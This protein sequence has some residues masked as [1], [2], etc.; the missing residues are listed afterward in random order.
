MTVFSQNEQLLKLEA[1]FEK[2][3]YETR[4]KKLK[5]ID[6]NKLSIPERALVEH[7]YG[8][9][10]YLYNSGNGAV[11][12]FIKAK[13]LYLKARDYDKATE[14]SLTI[15]EQKRLSEYKYEEYKPLLDEAIKYAEKSNK[16]N[17]L[18]TT[19][20][21]V[22]INLQESEPQK[23]IEFHKKGLKIAQRIK[24]KIYEV[25]FNRNIGLTYCEFL[26][27]FDKALYYQNLSLEQSKK[28]NYTEGI[29]YA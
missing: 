7:L 8:K 3:D 13:N 9:T 24:N 16:E 11:E 23:A 27:D 18:C 22:G 29:A 19:Y 12:H 5:G 21:E 2:M 20:L 6:T 1:E 25:K 28:L 14:L 17:L 26:K 10:Y 15:A 4:L